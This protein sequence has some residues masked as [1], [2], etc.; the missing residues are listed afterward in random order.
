MAEKRKVSD[1]FDPHE[2]GV[3]DWQDASLR[4]PQIPAGRPTV[5]TCQLM[6]L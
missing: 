3:N 4:V 6:W 5:R 1:A 2:E